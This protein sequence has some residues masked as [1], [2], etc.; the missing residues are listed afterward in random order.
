[1]SLS[2][3]IQFGYVIAV[4][5]LL[6]VGFGSV[7]YTLPKVRPIWKGAYWLAVGL[8]LVL[9]SIFAISA[10]RM[11]GFP[12]LP[13][14]NLLWALEAAIALTAVELSLVPYIHRKE[15]ELGPGTR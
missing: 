13:G 11:L 15:R 14:I 5:L 4:G 3:R 1:M 8:A 9:S 10:V 7:V 2:D 6:I 12:L